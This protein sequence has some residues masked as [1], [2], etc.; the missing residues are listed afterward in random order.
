M[1]RGFYPVMLSIVLACLCLASSVPPVFAA[2][3]HVSASA[4]RGSS[5]APVHRWRR[6]HWQRNSPGRWGF[7]HL[8]ELNQY[9]HGNSD[10]NSPKYSVGHNI[11]NSGNSGHNRGW[12]Q[13]NDSS[14]GN[15]LIAGNRLAHFRRINQYYYGN[16]DFNNPA[17]H[18]GY[19]QENNGNSGLND[20]IN[21]DNSSND[22]NQIIG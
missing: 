12:N 18:R 9:R 8:S 17:Y 3:A 1:R 16:S 20:G 21:Q 10:F 4:L 13:D 6:A 22:G 11:G 15:Q 14:G 5:A 2:S 19:N 7:W